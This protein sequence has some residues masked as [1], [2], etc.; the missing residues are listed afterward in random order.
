M[1]ALQPHPVVQQFQT[2]LGS[3]QTFAA[4]AFKLNK[5]QNSKVLARPAPKRV[6]FH[7]AAP[8]A[9]IIPGDT[10]V[11]Q[12]VTTGLSNF[13][14]LYNAA[15][16]CR[17]VLTW[18]PNPPAFIEGPLSTLCDPYLNLFRGIIPPL[19]GTLDFSPILAFLVLSVFTNTTAALGSE[20]GPDGRTPARR[21]RR[22]GSGLDW[23]P[24][25]KYQKAWARRVHGYR[26]MLQ[27]EQA[28]F[29]A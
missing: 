4:N 7:R 8:F 17:L 12:V 25:S 9:A 1:D 26:Q 20:V 14:S 19:G 6:V 27:Q 16:I 11:E 10:V 28:G 13:L 15:L 21:Q 3:F 29:K 22:S 18:F 5:Q 2:A 23:L 24:I